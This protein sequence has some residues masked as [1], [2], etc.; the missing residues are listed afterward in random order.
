MTGVFSGRPSRAADIGPACPS[1]REVALRL[2]AEVFE[3]FR[4]PFRR[5]STWAREHV[6]CFVRRVGAEVVSALFALDLPLHWPAN[7][8]RRRPAVR[9]VSGLDSL[10]TVPE[11]RG[12]G[13]ATE[14]LEWVHGWVVARGFA[15][16]ALFS[17]IG[18]A[19]YQAR[20]Y[21]VFPMPFLRGPLPADDP[22]RRARDYGRPFRDDDLPRVVE[23]YRAAARI[24]P[25]S[26]ARNREYWR[27]QLGWQS[28]VLDLRSTGSS[29]RDFVVSAR[30]PSCYV[31]SRHDG[32][33]FTVLETG[34]APGDQEALWRLARAEM[35]RAHREGCVRL[36]LHLPPWVQPP[37][38]LELRASWYETYLVRAA[39]GQIL[40]QVTGGGL[41]A[42]VFR[43]DYF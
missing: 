16:T 25:L 26:V 43:P 14:L 42:Y 39:P 9:M 2:A 21:T 23:T 33:I 37:R 31:R 28:Q 22:E 13:Y 7:R 17:E 4:A 18:P 29:E 12:R 36:V 35:G 1:E 40:P 20:G 5:E 32:D 10:V 27:Q 30:G 34:C 15:G 6:H 24:C 8:G 11:A 19:F 41:P 38:D 3:G